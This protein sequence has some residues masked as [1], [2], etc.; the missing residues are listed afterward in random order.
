MKISI[1]LNNPMYIYI[2]IHII[3][4]NIS[5]IQ[6]S[7]IAAVIENSRQAERARPGA[8]MEGL[9]DSFTW[10]YML[11]IVSY[12]YIYVYTHQKK[13]KTCVF[14]R[15]LISQKCRQVYPRL[16]FGAWIWMVNT[17]FFDFTSDM[18]VVTSEPRRTG[19]E[20]GWKSGWLLAELWQCRGHHMFS[21]ILFRFVLLKPDTC[22]VNARCQP[23]ACLRSLF[24]DGQRRIIPFFVSMGYGESS[25]EITIRGRTIQ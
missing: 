19:E 17:P 7:P 22:H 9:N 16:R 5:S 11:F 15:K 21:H 4:I 20:C 13:E 2:Y 25:Y 8:K 14:S 23:H 10:K 12:I 18:G 3:D 1:L 24:V 6:R